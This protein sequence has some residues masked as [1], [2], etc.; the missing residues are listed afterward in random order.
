MEGT[1]VLAAVCA[2]KHGDASAAVILTAQPRGVDGSW[3]L[4]VESE[5][6]VIPNIQAGTDGTPAHASVGALE[7]PAAM[8]AYIE[9][10]WRLG[11]NDKSS[12]SE[13]TKSHVDGTPG[14]ASISALEHAGSEAIND[15][16]CL[17]INGPRHNIETWQPAIDSAPAGSSVSTLEDAG[18]L[19]THIERRR[20]VG[21]DD[22]CADNAVGRIWVEGAPGHAPVGALEDPSYPRWSEGQ[23]AYV[24]RGGGFGV[25]RNTADSNVIGKASP[26][27]APGAAS[28][29]ALD[30]TIPA[31]CVERRLSLRVECDLC[32]REGRVDAAD[33]HAR[34]RPRPTPIDALENLA[35]GDT[36]IDGRRRMRIDEYPS[37]FGVG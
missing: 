12:H 37:N 17:R 14:E 31:C 21:I 9:G 5:G 26:E 6:D 2:L 28:I 23:K 18:D 15:I 29:C 8:A 30:D 11:I 33:G 24:E 32:N 7:Q 25:D 22:E 35:P 16:W 10:R 4:R 3:S 20:R 13:G 34:T 27:G 36:H 1:P 19:S